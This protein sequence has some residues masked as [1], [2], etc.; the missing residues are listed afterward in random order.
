M[1]LSYLLFLVV[2]LQMS[3]KAFPQNLTLNLPKDSISLEQLF[4]E[5]EKQTDLKFLYRYENIAGKTT[6]IHTETMDVFAVLDEALKTNG[7][8]FTIMEN[9][10]IV[11][12]LQTRSI[13]G[14]ITDAGNGSPIPA[15]T[16]FFTNTTV[17]VTTD[18]NGNYHLKIPGEGVYNLMVSHVGYQPV[19]KN[20]MPGMASTVID[21]AMQVRELDEV[22]VTEH[23]RSRRK[24][25]NLFWN[26]ILGKNPSKKTIQATNPE[27]VYYYYNPE[28]QILKVNCHEP[29]QIINYETGYHIQYFLSHFIYDYNTKIANWD[30]NCSFTELE[31]ENIKQQLYWEKNRKAVYHVSLTKLI[32]SLYN[33]SLSNNGF[34]LLSNLRQSE[35]LVSSNQSLSVHPDFMVLDN[36]TDNSKTLDLLTDEMLLLCYGRPVTDNDWTSIINVRSETGGI[37]N[38]SSRRWNREFS[39]IYRNVLYGGG[40]IHIYP[41]GT[42]TY[43]LTMVTMDESKPKLEGLSMSV[44]IDYDPDALISSIT[45]TENM[46]E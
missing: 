25:I 1:K 7:L 5:I 21:I 36:A 10:L 39:G 43:R 35:L 29:L 34:V 27:A 16:V 28:T 2:F 8:Q 31:P 11:V 40:T 3:V 45:T 4:I 32:K 37:Q 17:G 24:D 26:K 41:D 46:E 6:K 19:V 14:R 44:P 33:N 20:I 30:Y 13:S 15:A 42:F 23:V 38:V 18:M 12:S 22:D 9:N